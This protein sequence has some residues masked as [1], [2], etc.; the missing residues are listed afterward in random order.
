MRYDFPAGFLWGA[1][2]ASHQVEGNTRNSW[3]EWEIMPHR[4]AELHEN[5]LIERY[6]RENYI[7]GRGA[8][9]YARYE[10]DFKLARELGHTATRISIEWSR[11]E[12]EE[13][14]FDPLAIAH[15][16]KVIAAIRENGMEPFVT[17]W[18][19]T[20]PLWL[21]ARGGWQ[22]N[23]TQRLFERYARHMA[24]A[25]PDV[26]MWLT[27]NE[28][29]IYTGNSYMAGL[30][31]PQKR[32]PLAYSLVLEHLIAG[33]KL[34]YAAIK[35]VNAKNQISIAKNNIYFEAAGGALAPWNALVKRVADWWWN[36]Y[37]LNRI[38]RHMDFIGLNHYFHNR[39]DGWL[40]KNANEKISDLGWELHPESIY[41]VLCAL[42]KYGKPIYI[43][44]NGLADAHD[45]QR[46]WFLVESL[47][48]V[49]RAIAAGVQVRGYLHWSLMDN[50]EWAFG[51]WPRFGLIEINYKTLERRPRQSAYIYKKI[52]EANAIEE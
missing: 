8:D 26:R 10:E 28:P 52:C 39:I 36:D 34:A 50:F 7:S 32:N 9:H 48:H 44:E 33:H 16:Q 20:L 2:T 21:S 47:R 29:E 6:G 12:P 23:G 27:I 13:G 11:I 40:G 42:K 17:L 41:H 31:P 45:A 14:V 43:T 25:L 46:P 38:H 15:Y 51:F 1:S 4:L 18:H 35:G 3:S 19:W 24:H 22:S 5:G 49:H 37:F 30:W